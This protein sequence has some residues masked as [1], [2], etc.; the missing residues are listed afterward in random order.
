ME[1]I[2]LEKLTQEVNE[3]KN[4][5]DVEKFLLDHGEKIIDTMGSEVD[6]IEKKLKKKHP[7]VRHVDLETL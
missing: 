2:D 7:E 4:G 1:S 5:E 6:R 3:L